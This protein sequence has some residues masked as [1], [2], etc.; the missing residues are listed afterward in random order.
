SFLREY[1]PRFAGDGPALFY[2]DAHWDK[3]DLPLLEELRLIFERSPRAVVL[4]DDFEVWDDPGYSFDD[5][6]AG[7]RL[8]LDYLAPLAA[9]APRCFFPLGAAGETGGR[10]GCV[11]L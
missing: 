7:R 3:Q 10:R 4:I 8:T 2:L 9:F 6:G 11:V 5:Y 1:L